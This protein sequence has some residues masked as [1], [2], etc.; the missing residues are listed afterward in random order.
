MRDDI[1][2]TRWLFHDHEAVTIEV[3]YR[4]N[5]PVD[6]LVFGIGV[7]RADGLEIHGNNTDID[8][9]DTPLPEA[10]MD[11]AYPANGT[12]R[13]RIKRLGL[14]ES[15][16]YLDVAAHRR[17]GFPFDYH[18]RLHKFS[19]R[20]SLRVSGIF[21]PEHQWEFA[22]DYVSAQ[23]GQGERETKRAVRG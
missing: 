12:F 5:R 18:H 9:I 6:D 15:S 4:I 3:S 20:S 13:Y 17:D 7:L 11:S 2:V 19:V 8:R 1:G 23:S 10:T 21:N 14:L 16:Y 22:P